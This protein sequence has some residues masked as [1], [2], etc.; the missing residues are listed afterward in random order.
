MPSHG[1]VCCLL[2]AEEMQCQAPASFT[3][4]EQKPKLTDTHEGPVGAVLREGGPCVTCQE[5][6]LAPRIC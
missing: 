4:S 2:Q 3:S 6:L 5:L 1:S